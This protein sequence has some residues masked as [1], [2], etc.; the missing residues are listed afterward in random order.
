V[1]VKRLIGTHGV[2]EGD[3]GTQ[4]AGEDESHSEP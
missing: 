3:V 2:V 4:E 1:V